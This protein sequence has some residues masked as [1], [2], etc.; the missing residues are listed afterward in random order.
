MSSLGNVV[1][2]KVR[3]KVGDG[4]DGD[5]ENEEMEFI[6]RNLNRVDCGRRESAV[7]VRGARW[8]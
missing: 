1:S 7:L 6:K 2:L 3:S 5:E 4:E 8:I